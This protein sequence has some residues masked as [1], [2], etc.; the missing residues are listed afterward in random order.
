MPSAP[1]PYAPETS[2]APRDRA[3]VPPLVDSP[4]EATAE[5]DERIGPGQP[6]P[7]GTRR[8][9]DSSTVTL[10]G[11]GA[12]TGDPGAATKRDLEKEAGESGGGY[13]KRKDG[14]VVV[15]WKGAD[16]PACPLN[17][18]NGRRIAGTFAVAG[19]TLLAPLSSSMIAPAASQVAAR[20]HIADEVEI[21]MS[22]SIFV[23]AFAFSPLVFGP[24]SELFGR[25]RV[26]QTANLFYIIFNLVCAFAK[27]KGQFIAFRFLGGF[28]GG[29]PLSIG[30]GVLSDLWRPE[31][32]GKSSALYSLGPLLGPALGPVMG[33]WVTE[34]VPVD[35]YRWIFFSTTIF[36]AL[37]QL[38]GLFFL[39]ETYGPVLLLRKALALKQEMGLP[40]DSDRVQTVYEAKM[41]GKRKS[42]RDIIAHGMV[43]PFVLFFHEPILQLLA[44]YMALIYGVIYILIV[45]T[46]RVYQE[47]YSQ[48]VGIASL[49][50][51][52]LML[53]FII[54]SQGGARVLDI[55][56]RRLKAKENGVGRP[57]F[58]LPLMLPA[59]VLL[60]AGLLIYG[61]GA[62]RG[63][64]WIVPDIGLV[65]IGTAMITIFQGITTYLLDAFT[66]YAASALA[67]TTCLRSIC[68]FAFPL[69]APYMYNGIGYGWGCTVLAFV[70]IAV[71][72][73][74]VPLLWR[75]GERI[76]KHSKFAAKEQGT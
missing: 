12:A 23:L 26:L 59:S 33:G 28:G 52:A 10:Q 3:T 45:S 55:L 58:R 54:A 35:G 53:G 19:F 38:L 41:N 1:V 61:W 43:R 11:D 27:T 56:Y 15:D 44:L 6:A 65:L 22:V 71:G 46:D 47:V 5:A 31:E 25:V 4:P 39:T 37:V 16:D 64:H 24:A 34:R 63:V 40:A 72:C 18:S 62:E 49:H 75:Y 9:S 48:S 69:F 13:E 42:T 7:E 68:G 36:S 66:L 67:A 20:L 73:P 32:R 30:A 76:R 8:G 17:W 51:I 14:V 74:A 21:S 50:F 60:P 29:A 2:Q 57:E 70:A